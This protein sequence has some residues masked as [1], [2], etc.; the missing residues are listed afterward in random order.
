VRPT[1]EQGGRTGG[2]TQRAAAAGA[3][4]NEYYMPKKKLTQMSHQ[5]ATL[6]SKRTQGSSSGANQL[7]AMQHTVTAFYQHLSD[8][9]KE[10]SNEIEQLTSIIRPQKVA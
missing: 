2:Y 6:S 10:H 8:K 9:G 5:A 4:F 7:G 1:T 3:E